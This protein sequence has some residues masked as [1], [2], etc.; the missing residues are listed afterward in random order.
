MANI[1]V[2]K[3]SLMGEA[4]NSNT[5]VDVFLDEWQ[6]ADKNDVIS[7]RDFFAD[8]IPHLSGE[9]FVA[10]TIPE[11]E[12][13]EKQKHDVMLSDELVTEFLAADVLVL[14]V[15]MYNFGIPSSLKA[16]IDHISRVGKTFRYT[17]DGPVGLAENKKAYVLGARGGFYLD[18]PKDT[19]T[20]YLKSILG[21]F[22]LNDVTFVVAEGLNISPAQKKKS[23][24]EAKDKIL[25][26]LNQ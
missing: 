1:L 16:Y 8:P 7:I 5:L 22:G 9:Q 2:I 24:Q 23:M 26:L 25:K 13:S 4:G 14:G 3:S 15:P 18:T 20:P 21:L 17:A 12:R 19:Q 10:F 11:D 6:A